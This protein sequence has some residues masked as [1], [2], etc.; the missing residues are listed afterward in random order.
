L[1]EAGDVVAR[2]KWI[3]GHEFLVRIYS[4]ILASRKPENYR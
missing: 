3:G 2:A 1:F 4:N